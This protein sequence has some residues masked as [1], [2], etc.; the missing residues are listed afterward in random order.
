[1]E[2]APDPPSST[3]QR[4]IYE[5]RA[6]NLRIGIQF[7]ARGVALAVDNETDQ[8]IAIDPSEISIQTTVGLFH[9]MTVHQLAL[10]GYGA[11]G[12]G[13]DIEPHS[14]AGFILSGFCAPNYCAGNQLTNPAMH[15][16][17]IIEHIQ[18]GS[19]ELHRTQ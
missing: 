8:P 16:A 5:F 11:P 19:Y 12:A 2:A 13:V 1:T 15:V 9:P 4:G 10:M 3:D 17:G 18:V 6:P 14:R 7:A